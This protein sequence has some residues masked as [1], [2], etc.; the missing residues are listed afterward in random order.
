MRN[1]YNSSQL[2]HYLFEL[3]QA[4]TDHSVKALS[5]FL[6]GGIPDDWLGTAIRYMS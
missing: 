6:K 3:M 4:G 5:G 2:V 1:K